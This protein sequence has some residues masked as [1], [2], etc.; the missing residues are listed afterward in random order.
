MTFLW[1][2]M[3]IINSNKNEIIR[4]DGLIFKYKENI[5]L[6]HY[7]FIVNLFKDNLIFFLENI[8]NDS[9]VWFYESNYAMQTKNVII[10]WDQRHESN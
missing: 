1:D 2:Q 10:K 8:R 9:Y 6:I 4:I 7:I 3:P 5:S